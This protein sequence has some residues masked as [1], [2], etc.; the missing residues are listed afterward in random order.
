MN[1]STEASSVPARSG[2][3]PEPPDSPPARPQRWWPWWLA[4][5]IFV[6]LAGAVLAAFTVE[7]PY[8]EFRPG[9]ARPT[10]RLVRVDEVEAYPPASDI[11]FTTVSLRRSTLASRV[12]AWFDDD[13]QVVDEEVILGDRSPDENRQFNLQLMDT[14]KQD[15]IR[16]AL[17]SLGHEVP[18]TIDGMV[19]V[20]L[21]Q[22]S[23][24]EGVLSVGD[25]VVAIDGRPLAEL[26]DVGEIMTGKLPGETVQLVVE[27]PDRSGEET[28][29]IVLGPDPDDPARGIIGVSLQPREPQYRFPF[30][31]DIDSGNVGGPSAGLAFSLGVIDVLTPGELTGGQRVAVTGTVDSA[32][33]VGPVG[34]VAQKTAVVVGEDY[35]VFLV[36][37][38]EVEEARIRAGDDVRVI[39]VDTLQDALD[40]LES[41]GGSGFELA[42]QPG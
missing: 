4:G 39:P 29:E 17:V 35:D 15:A 34:G 25:T 26:D 12:A 5:G 10:A 1:V 37:S 31:I 19:V 20:Q 27:P 42:S 3:V 9:S 40:A 28:V 8:Y 18:V 6:L 41:L 14:S 11:A 36:P 22:G 21:L 38:S 33:N 24:A 13:V 2:A 7:L 30:P 32:G 16:L 23:A